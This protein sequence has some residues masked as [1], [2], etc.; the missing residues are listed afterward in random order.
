MLVSVEVKVSVDVIGVDKEVH[1]SQPELQVVVQDGAG[2]VIKLPPG[3]QE[4]DRPSQTDSTLRIGGGMFLLSIMFSGG[5]Q[6]PQVI[7][8]QDDRAINQRG[9]NISGRNEIQCRK[10]VIHT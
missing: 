8:N 5:N 7:I 6:V 1:T 10:K 3:G 4:K 2:T 9:V